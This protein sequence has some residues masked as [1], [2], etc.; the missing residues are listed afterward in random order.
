MFVQAEG[1]D[2]DLVLVATHHVAGGEIVG[3]RADDAVD[4]TQKPVHDRAVEHLQ[5][6][7][8]DNVGMVG[9]DGRPL[10]P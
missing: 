1:N 3:R 8:P 6:A 2:L 5:S 10:R 9:Q 7:L 4:G